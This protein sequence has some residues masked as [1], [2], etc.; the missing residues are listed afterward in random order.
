LVPSSGGGKKKVILSNMLIYR[1]ACCVTK[2]SD[3]HAHTEKE[4]K[5]RY[6]AREMPQWLQ[7]AWATFLEDNGLIPRIHI[8]GA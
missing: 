8:H 3:T 7:K 2:D 1:P 4:K 6:G 5:K